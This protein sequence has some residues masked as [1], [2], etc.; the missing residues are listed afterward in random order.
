[1]IVASAPPPALYVQC[2]AWHLAPGRGFIN[3]WREGQLERENEGGR[4]K[5]RNKKNEFIIPQREWCALY[6]SRPSDYKFPYRWGVLVWVLQL[7]TSFHTLKV[8]PFF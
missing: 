8:N 4:R 5:K 3:I 2:L 7:S 6:K 1:M